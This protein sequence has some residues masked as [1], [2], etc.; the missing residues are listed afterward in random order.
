[1]KF[2]SN[3]LKRTSDA[4]SDYFASVPDSV[5]KH[6][7][8]V[9]LLFIAITAFAVMGLGKVK[10]DMTIE[11]WFEKDDPTLVSLNAFRTQFGSEDNLYIIYR[12]KDGNVFSE[13]S[14]RT[15]AAIRDD[16]LDRRL[17]VADGQTSPLQRI[18]KVTGIDNAPV[19]KAEGDAL[20][21]RHL[22]GKTIPTD[23]GQLS[24]LRKLAD[25]QET[26][27]RLYYSADGE[28]GAIVVETNFGT[29][30][31]DAPAGDAGDAG[32]APAPASIEDISMTFDETDTAATETVQFKST[33]L[34]EYYDF[35]RE[36]QV[37]LNKPEFAK[38]FEYL[39][40]GNAAATEH[41]MKVLE[42][43]GVL[44][45]GMLAMMVVVLWFLFRSPA[46]V[47]W[48]LTVVVVTC[49]WTLGFV[50]WLGYTVTA[51]LILTVVMILV[52]GIADTIHMLSGYVYYRNQGEDHATALR[53]SYRAAAVACLL[54][55]LTTGLGMMSVLMTPIA[56]IKV[57]GVMTAAGVTLAFVI[58]IYVLPLMLDLW[59]PAKAQPTDAKPSVLSLRRY[60]PDFGA[61]MQ[62]LLVHVLPFVTRARTP[63]LAVSTVVLGLCFYGATQVKVD[64]DPVAQYPEDASIRENFRIADKEMIGSQSMVIYIDLGEEFAFHD[65]VALKRI[66]TLQATLERKYGKYV[67]RTASLVDVVRKSYQTLNEE[68][69]EMYKIPETR[70]LVGQTLFMFDNSNATERRRMVSDDYDRAHITVYMRNAGSYEYTRV[71]DDMSRDIDIAIADLKTTYPDAKASITGMFSL[72]MKGSDYLSWTS[73]TS[74]GMAIATI[75]V[76]LLLMFGSFKAGLIAIVANAVPSM[77]SFGLMGLLGIPLDFTTVLIAPIIVGIAVDDTIHFMTYYRS[78]VSIDGDV[79]RALRDTIAKVGQA[80]TYSS[81][82]LGLGLA[83]LM[84]SASVG[85][86]NVGLFG[87]LAIFAGLAC[88]LLLLP[89][90]IQLFQ[91]RFEGDAAVDAEP[92]AA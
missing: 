4:M 34:A 27:P 22:V 86:A 52:I 70:D 8:L 62:R 49:V 59:W 2:L 83:I 91:L 19:L 31:V 21:S 28:Y 47:L 60:L 20:I 50:G 63:I 64:T 10:F 42:E 87:S 88:E 36:V 14:L 3:T 85:N 46:G 35:M 45:L 72:I 7:Y 12:A 53:H 54:T 37:T 51:F 25:T 77:L 55:M 33:D 41:D 65:P 17:A 44:Y 18:V 75:S 58:T 6:K 81:L 82:I 73:L 32:A 11:G 43:M 56:P 89:A 74:F 16:L 24:E 80:V 66:E 1:M 9:W 48:P 40:V 71:F 69:R 92:V 29:V 78:E 84:L 79:T 13:Q 5:L 38:H 39:P 15:A 57:F 26:F 67:I 23:A 61:M 30:P 76:V 68:R 90:L